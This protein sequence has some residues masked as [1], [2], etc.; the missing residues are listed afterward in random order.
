MENRNLLDGPYRDSG[1]TYGFWVLCGDWEC[2]QKG[3]F[4][5]GFARETVF[6]EYEEELTSF[7]LWS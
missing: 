6:L 4:P 7:I 5:R 2:Y 1:D 3:I